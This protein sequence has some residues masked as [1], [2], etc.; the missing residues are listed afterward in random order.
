MDCESIKALSHEA[1]TG[2]EKKL[3]GMSNRDK[4]VS[5]DQI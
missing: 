4:D 3:R 1:I 5:Q 2:G